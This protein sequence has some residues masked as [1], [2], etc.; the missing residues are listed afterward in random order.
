MNRSALVLVTSSYPIAGDGSEA[1]GSFVADLVEEIA[2]HVP[3]RVV[4]P[5]PISTREQWAER[6]EIYRYP[7]PSRPLSTLRLWHPADQLRIAKVLHA[8]M[9]ATREA[10]TQGAGHILAL[11]GLPCGQWARKAAK[12]TGLAYSVWMLGSDVW[13]LG[14]IPLLRGILS[15]VIR[16]AHRAYADGYQLAEDARRIGD[17]SVHFLPSTRRINL[18]DPAKPRET[19]PYRMLFLGRWHPNKGIDI[20]LDALAKFDTDTWKKI[21]KIEINGGGP[22][23]PLVHERANA[24]R[25][26]GHP[27]SVGGYLTKSE[28]EA[29]IARAD[30]LLIPSRIESIPVV[31]SDAMKLGRPVVAMPVGD[32]PILLHRAPCGVLASRANAAAYCDAL[33]TA[34]ATPPSLLVDGVKTTSS[35]FDLP[36]IA[37]QITQ[38]VS[39]HD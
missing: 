23:E 27:I 31:F 29:A 14:R 38:Q 26:M 35:H 10:S 7:A 2:K 33:R 13:S 20:L 21:E 17:S 16:D 18:K 39:D 22:L 36:T 15:R 11:W 34:L 24:L 28:A 30:W 19:P 5:G 25:N 4:A 37:K 9:Q 6:I 32:L 12:E 8:G 3:V 1:A